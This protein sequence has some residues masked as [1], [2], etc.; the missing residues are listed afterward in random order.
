MILE[1]YEDKT[2]ITSG[3]FIRLAN[4]EFFNGL[5]F[6]RVIDAG[7]GFDHLGGNPRGGAGLG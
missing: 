2:P 1:L 3:N 7:F 6:H 5:V 4:D